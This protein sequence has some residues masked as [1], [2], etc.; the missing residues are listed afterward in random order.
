[1]AEIPQEQILRFLQDAPMFGDLDED[2]LEHLVQITQIQRLAVGDWVFREGDPG[3][4]WYVVYDGEVEVVK[5][6]KDGVRVIAHE[7]AVTVASAPG[8]GSSFTVTVPLV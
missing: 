3:D 1:M 6:M 4:A 8:N 7:G 2:E 5:E